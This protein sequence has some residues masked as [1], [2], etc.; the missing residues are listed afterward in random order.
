MYYNFLQHFMTPV[1]EL[2]I[3]R[4]LDSTHRLSISQPVENADRKMLLELF[5]LSKKATGFRRVQT[6]I[7]IIDFVYDMQ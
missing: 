4:L 6:I 3:G 1:T 7:S 5:R 2:L